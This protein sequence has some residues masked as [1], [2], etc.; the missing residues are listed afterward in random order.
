[1]NITSNWMIGRLVHGNAWV[2]RV[3]KAIL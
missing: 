2:V 3:E 1:M